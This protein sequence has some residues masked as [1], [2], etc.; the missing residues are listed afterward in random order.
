MFK[1]VTISAIVMAAALASGCA[2]QRETGMLVGGV[3][4]MAVGGPLGSGA[5]AHIAGGVIGGALGAAVGGSIGGKMDARDRAL[6]TKSVETS[7]T[8]KWTS[9]SGAEMKVET[10]EV[11]PVKK[12]VTITSDDN[13]ETMTVIK[14]QN[15]WIKE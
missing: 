2:T 1:I 5:A 3:V 15:K 8:Q 4:G 11:T 9:K 14:K 12:T 13:T 6:L 10:V 7:T